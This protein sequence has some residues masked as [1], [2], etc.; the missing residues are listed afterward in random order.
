M[1]AP[2][3][4][5][6]EPQYEPSGDYYP[7]DAGASDIVSSI[8]QNGSAQDSVLRYAAAVAAQ[9]RPVETP[10]PAATPEASASAAA[11]NALAHKCMALE[12]QVAKLSKATEPLPVFFGRVLG[13]SEGKIKL[14]SEHAT[15]LIPEPN[16]VAQAS[17]GRWLSLSHPKFVYDTPLPSGGIS[18]ETW[19][20]VN[21][22]TADTGDHQTL[23]AREKTPSGGKSF[24]TFSAVPE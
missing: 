15:S 24:S 20:Q 21:I 9:Q 22:A 14:Y 8:E 4:Q 13:G 10:K 11:L 6:Y 5:R 2:P 1:A 7:D 18:S 12:A 16:A 17:V 19:Y 23:W 3:P